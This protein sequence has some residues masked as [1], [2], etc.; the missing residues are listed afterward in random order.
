MLEI[1]RI[2]ARLQARFRKKVENQMLIDDGHISAVNPRIS[3]KARPH[4][5]DEKYY[6]KFEKKNQNYE[7]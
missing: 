6:G 7:D 3:E 4:E 1:F 5:F 2:M